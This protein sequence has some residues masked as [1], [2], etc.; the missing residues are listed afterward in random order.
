MASP[1]E[2]TNAEKCALGAMA[3]SKATRTSSSSV[4]SMLRLGEFAP[5]NKSSGA[6]TELP[7]RLSNA[8]SLQGSES[9]CEQ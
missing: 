6:L 3:L 7:H 5:F 2:A 1:E 8:G 9:K 4:D